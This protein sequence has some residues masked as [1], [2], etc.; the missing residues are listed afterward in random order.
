MTIPV[1]AVATNDVLYQDNLEQIMP[2]QEEV[3]NEYDYIVKI[4]NASKA[5]KLQMGIS[6]KEIEYIESNSIES[7]LLYRASLSEQE[8]RDYYCYSDE[9]IRILKEYDGSR[10]ED[11]PKMR[12]ATAT[13]TASLGYVTKSS[14]R[15]GIIYAWNWSTMPNLL[16]TDCVAVTW[17]GT[18]ANG[19]NNNMRFDAYSS[20]CNVTY[21]KGD[22][23]VETI[24]I[25]NINTNVDL[26]T[27]AAATFSMGLSSRW[28]KE[29]A[30]YVYVDLVNTTSGPN[31]YEL[32]AHAE[33]AHYTFTA[34]PS[35]SYPR[36]LTINFSGSNEVLG[37]KDLVVR[38]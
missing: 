38:I 3:F 29:G 27:G 34:T 26:Y 9:T 19:K 36:A 37:K 20:F 17:Q 12:T 4:R 30:F 33:Y 23:T 14:T 1:G 31:L 24:A 6:S 5:E 25:R 21:K 8:L 35:V 15:V 22:G 13:L 11:V 18:Y 28:A 7:E 10:L 32:I 2:I 16:R